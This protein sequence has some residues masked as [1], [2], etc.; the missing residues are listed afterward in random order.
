MCGIAGM[1]SLG[2]GDRGL[3]ENARQRLEAMVSSM[4]HRGPDDSGIWIQPA[5]LAGF[6][7]NRLSIVDLSSRGHQPMSYANNKLTITFNGEVYNFRELKL[8]LAA[9]GYEFR[10]NTDTEVV[11]AAVHHWGLQEALRRFRGMFA[12]AIWN[13]ETR[14]LYLARDRLGEKP[15][16]LS[17]KNGVLY[18]GSELRSLLTVAEL[19]SGLNP[20]AIWTLLK[21]GYITE[22]QSIVDGIYK[23]PAAHVLT[24]RH[25]DR[26]PLEIGRHPSSEADR[27]G[28]IAP[29]KYWSLAGMDDTKPE[30]TQYGFG[31]RLETLESLIKDTVRSQMQCDV[32]YGVFLSGG[33]D[34][35]II[36][37]TMQAES[38]QPVHTFTVRFDDPD[39]DEGEISG[40]LARHLGTNHH[41]LWLKQDEIV[42]NIPVLSGQL[43]EPT[44]NASIFAATLMS[45]LA[46]ASVKVCLG[47]DG[48]DE[49]FSGY[50]RYLL[51]QGQWKNVHRIPGPLRTAASG[52]LSLPSR[53][54]WAWLD[55]LPRSGSSHPVQ[56]RL[57]QQIWK[58]K[59]ILQSENIVDAYDR[60]VSLWRDPSDLLQGEAGIDL[61]WPESDRAGAL[62]KLVG[63]DILTYLP[64]DNL[65]KL[66]RASM[67]TSLEMRQPLLDHPIVEFGFGLPD[68]LKIRNGETKWLLKQLLYKL[69]PKELVCRPKMGFTAPIERWLKGP[70]KDWSMD[71]LND[72]RLTRDGYL[73]PNVVRGCLNDFH[74]GRGCT[75]GQVWALAVLHAWYEN[76]ERG[77]SA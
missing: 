42:D 7:H 44:A 62:R 69:V 16:F 5:H 59:G 55:N 1:F 4:S 6:G 49:G 33:V 60:V 67:S 45:R 23:L 37:A 76:F 35:T 61:Q 17:Q 22:P 36:A 11:L 64:G 65:A 30:A 41:E 47:G 12:F 21:L 24:I 38:N 40:K 2:S 57:P 50:N 66:D 31:A 34:S 18:F 52:L 73:E 72:S 20:D 77:P 8:E 74:A 25:G 53:R 75:A 48:G 9:M 26:R 14:E 51:T 27:A 70:L 68:N 29:E 15:L 39:F 63:W 71:L 28:R 19:R 13:D 56:N 46:R 54:M 10:S 3:P 43:D 32:P 58:L